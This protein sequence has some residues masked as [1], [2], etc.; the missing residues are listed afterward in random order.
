MSTYAEE[1]EKIRDRHIDARRRCVSVVTAQTA[2]SIEKRMGKKH[3]RNAHH[4]SRPWIQIDADSKESLDLSSLFSISSFDVLLTQRN[5]ASSRSA[6]SSCTLGNSAPPSHT[7]STP[8][9]VHSHR[10]PLRPARPNKSCTCVLLPE[11]SSSA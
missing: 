6:P 9:R 10:T 2:V 5:R 7:S 3:A 4:T 11:H 8:R 1:R